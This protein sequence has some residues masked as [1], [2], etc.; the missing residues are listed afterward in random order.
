MKINFNVCVDHDKVC[1]GRYFREEGNIL[2]AQTNRYMQ[3]YGEADSL[4]DI[5]RGEEPKS[6]IRIIFNVI[7]SHKTNL[8]P[9]SRATAHRLRSRK[10]IPFSFVFTPVLVVS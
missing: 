3:E 4:S 9:I 10:T 5:V 8:H 7:M 2:W 1:S 6:G